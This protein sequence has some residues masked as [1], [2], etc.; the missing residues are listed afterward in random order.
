LVSG[1]VCC[2][3][4]TDDEVFMTRNFNV[5]QKTT[6]RYLITHISKPEAEVTNN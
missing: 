2:S 1:V 4:E 5:A 6:E 3:R